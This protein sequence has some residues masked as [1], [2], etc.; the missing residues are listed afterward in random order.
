MTVLEERV[1]AGQL[2]TN[3]VFRAM[4]GSLEPSPDTK[5][6][7]VQLD[8]F[9]CGLNFPLSKFMLEVLDFYKVQLIHLAPNSVLF[10]DIF[11][12]L[13]EAYL[14]TML[15][16][17]LLCHYF[18]MKKT[19]K[20]KLQ[21]ASSCSLLLGNNKSKEYIDTPSR[22]SCMPPSAR[23]AIARRG[24]TEP[25]FQN[26][27]AVPFEF[28]STHSEGSDYLEAM[29]AAIADLKARSLTGMHVVG[30][31]VRRRILPLKTRK[32]PVWVNP[33]G[34]DP[35]QDGDCKSPPSF[36]FF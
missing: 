34:H 5:E 2:P 10:L 11:V 23:W 8:H 36:E 9:Q 19:V 35:D 13:C 25:E 31:F 24:S 4:A 28:W 18:I 21:V 22:N 3:I 27:T 14:G 26:V 16:F 7:V 1:S 32:D 15:S 20:D 12:H 6:V 29:A 17:A 30:D 33:A